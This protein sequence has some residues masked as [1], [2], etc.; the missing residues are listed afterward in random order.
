[1][2][3]IKVS[4]NSRTASVAGAIAGTVREDGKAEIQSLEQAQ[5]TRQ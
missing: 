4:S 3:L 1:M 2:D 5:L